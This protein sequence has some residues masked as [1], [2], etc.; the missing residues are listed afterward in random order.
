MKLLFAIFGLFFFSKAAFA[1]IGELEWG[2]DNKRKSTLLD[3]YPDKGFDFYTYRISGNGLLQANRVSRYLYGEEVLNKKIENKVDGKTVTL[4]SMMTFNGTLLGF[5]ADKRD[6]ENQLYMVK[7]DTEIDPFD[8]PILMAEFPS[9]KIGSNKGYFMVQKS[10]NDNFLCVEYVIPAKKDN[11]DRYGF[12]IIDTNYSTVRQGEYEVPFSSR[13]SKVNVRHITNDGEF[14]LGVT[15]YN[16][17]NGSVWRDYSAIDKAV[18]LHVQKD[19][20]MQY[21]LLLDQRRVF[22]FEITSRDSILVVTGTYG[23]QFAAG[24]QGVFYQRINMKK[25]TIEATKVQPFPEWFMEDLKAKTIRYDRVRTVNSNN[26]FRGGLDVVNYAFRDVHQLDDGSLVVVAEQYYVYLQTTN[27]SRGM[28]QTVYHY[29]YDDALIYQISP[30]GDFNWISSIPKEQHSTN[31]FGYYSSLKSIVS[32]GKC[33]VFFNDHRKNYDEYGEYKRFNYSITFPVRKKSYALAVS[34]ISL[35]N[36]D[37]KRSVF[38]EYSQTGGTV[39]LKMCT[40]NPKYK[41]MLFFSSGKRERFG[42]LKY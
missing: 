9:P 11:F 3:L 10:K 33:F 4:E 5:F 13:Y 41:E 1:Q 28:V 12:H 18:I 2:V 21:E 37:Q 25:R 38:N 17:T 8:E 15:V 34:E 42:L 14:V 22:D 31:D 39:A 19:T 24:A 29:Y 26:T 6:G 23:E 32:G 27:D 30:Q 7:F 40:N 36:G 35:A 20:L 16:S